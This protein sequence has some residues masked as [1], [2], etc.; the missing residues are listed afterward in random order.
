MT[1]QKGPLRPGH[2]DGDGVAADHHAVPVHSLE[3]ER[4]RTE[5]EHKRELP[6]RAVEPGDREWGCADR[7]LSRG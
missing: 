6:M 1:E 7:S 4:L 3:R 2:R 5:R